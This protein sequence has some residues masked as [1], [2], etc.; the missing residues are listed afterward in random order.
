MAKTARDFRNELT[1]L[2]KVPDIFVLLW[3]SL[4]QRSA[5]RSPEALACAGFA[6]DLQPKKMWTSSQVIEN[7]GEKTTS[8]SP[9][10]EQRA[11]VQG[12][13]S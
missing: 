13:A 5:R 8:P 7:G 9:A 12:R 10:R 1:N 6:F 4:E 3:P 11:A 2:I